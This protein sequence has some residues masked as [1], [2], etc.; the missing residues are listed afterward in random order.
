LAFIDI[1]ILI[2]HQASICENMPLRL[3]IYIARIYEKLID[4]D[5]VYMRKLVKLPK[6]D[7]LVLYNGADAFP[8]EKTMRLSDAY[9]HVP[10]E[11]IATQ[12]QVSI[13]AVTILQSALAE[14]AAAGSS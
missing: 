10:V 8:D 14:Q 12:R 13:S 9:D 7:F 4:N 5:A 3:L 11:T 6:P 1:D 2:E